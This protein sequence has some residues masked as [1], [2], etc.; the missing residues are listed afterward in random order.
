MKYIKLFEEHL[1]T[2][3]WKEDHGYDSEGTTTIDGTAL[4]DGMSIKKL[5]KLWKKDIKLEK[6]IG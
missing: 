2:E 5:M 3:G 4:T 6:K 1:L